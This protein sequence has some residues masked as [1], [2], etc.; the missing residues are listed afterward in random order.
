MNAI[1][2]QPAAPA[3]VGQAA[4]L[5]ALPAGIYA[6]ECMAEVK[7]A[8]RTPVFLYPT[9]ATPAAFYAL[10]AIGMGMDPGQATRTLATF[11]VFA[12]IGPALFGFGTGVAAERETGQLAAKRLSP[13]P[14]A[15]HLLAK[16]AACTLFTA[17]AFGIVYALGLLGAGVR[18]EAWRWPLVAAVHLAAVL[19]FAL[20]GLGLGYRFGSKG[21]VALANL[22]FL[23]FAVLGGLWMPIEALPEVLRSLAWATPSYH[24]GELAMAAADIARP[25]SI[26]AHIGVLAGLTAAAGLF[27]ATGWRSARA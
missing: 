20:I 12:A 1:V 3:V 2:I 13:M 15:A 26:A 21:A 11:G 9:L 14:A 18:I 6:R 10:F 22:L 24:L 19:P 25:G 7:K 4:H 17:V 16:L 5:P 23:A 27:A 8:W